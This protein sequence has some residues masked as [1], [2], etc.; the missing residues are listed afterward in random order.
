M[1]DSKF[2]FALSVGHPPYVSPILALPIFPLPFSFL[3]ST[4]L[5]P[6]HPQVIEICGKR[7]QDSSRV[8]ACLQ[9]RSLGV[10]GANM[11]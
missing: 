1:L 9:A 7:S 11:S 2:R 10:I 4:L 5:A 6:L 8:K 3:P